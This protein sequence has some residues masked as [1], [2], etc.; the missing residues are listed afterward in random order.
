MYVILALL[1]T[2]LGA[3]CNVKIYPH[4]M[5][6]YEVC[7]VTKESVHKKLWEF[8]PDNASKVSTWCIAIPEDI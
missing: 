6:N 4:I 2:D 7:A 5:P 3:D 1:C 8:A